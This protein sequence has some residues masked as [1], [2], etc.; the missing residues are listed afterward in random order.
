MEGGIAHITERWKVI[1][2][3]CFEKIGMK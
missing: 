2:K 1:S 3:G